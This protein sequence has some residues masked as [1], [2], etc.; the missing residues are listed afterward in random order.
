MTSVLA[1]PGSRPERRLTLEEMRASFRADRSPLHENAVAA[2]PNPPQDAANRGVSQNQDG[3][4]HETY[5][6]PGDS[7]PLLPYLRAAR[8]ARG[9]RTKSLR[10]PRLKLDATET[11]YSRMRSHLLALSLRALNDA[12]LAGLMPPTATELADALA[13]YVH[14]EAPHLIYVHEPGTPAMPHRRRRAYLDGPEAV[15]RLCTWV[16][17]AR[18][19]WSPAWI[20]TKQQNGTKAKGVP[21]PTRTAAA[22]WADP[23]RLAELA[24][25]MDRETN[26]QL[27]ARFG[28]SPSTLHRGLRELGGRGS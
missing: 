21:K 14:T 24:E 7:Y 1:D 19:A 28:V 6:Y 27:C 20:K 8:R 12:T 18:S 9:S 5:S 22:T 16:A 10:T 2:N 15:D 25:H 17:R 23:E 3:G 26:A 11:A 13:Q 4:C